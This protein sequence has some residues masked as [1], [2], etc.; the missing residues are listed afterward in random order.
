MLECT[1]HWRSYKNF[2]FSDF[3]PQLLLRLYWCLFSDFYVCVPEPERC[4]HRRS[5]PAFFKDSCK[6]FVKDWNESATTARSSGYVRLFIGCN[7]VRPEQLWSVIARSNIKDRTLYV[8]MIFV[9]VITDHWSELFGPYRS[10]AYKKG[11]RNRCLALLLGLIPMLFVCWLIQLLKCS[12]SLSITSQLLKMQEIIVILS[13]KM[14]VHWLS[15]GSFLLRTHQQS[16]LL[17]SVNTSKRQSVPRLIYSHDFSADAIDCEFIE[18]RVQ[19]DLMEFKPD[20]KHIERV[21]MKEPD[22]YAASIRGAIGDLR[23]VNCTHSKLYYCVYSEK[24]VQST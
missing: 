5:F 9:R 7:T 19:E 21:S 3:N 18:C 16:V 20:W 10:A 2:N 4:L 14:N 13:V 23:A 11:A 1:H 8:S 12:S 6:I 17:Y 22:Q 15:S 24:L